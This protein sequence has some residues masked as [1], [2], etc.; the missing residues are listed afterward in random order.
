[1]DYGF[2]IALHG[3]P[4]CDGDLDVVKSI[5]KKGETSLMR[6]FNKMALGLSSVCM[7]TATSVFVS[8]A[9]NRNMSSGMPGMNMTASQS[10]NTVLTKAL[11]NELNGFTR[12]Q[13]YIHLKQWTPATR[14]AGQ[15]HD[16][17]HAVI[18]PPLEAKK[19]TVYGEAIHSKYDALQSAI[20][21]HQVAQIN[22]LIAVNTKNI[23]IVARI[24]NVHLSQ[25]GSSKNKG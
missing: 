24:L 11:N 3:G 12:I 6:K 23:S 10:H 15:L 9:M 21:M 8:Y 2:W 17:F 1:M 22:K 20:Q 4:K 7:I 5:S 13:K 14:L 25:S 19:G 16:Q 18:L